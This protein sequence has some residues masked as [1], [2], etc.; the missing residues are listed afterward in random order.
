MVVR[1]LPPM[2]S[3]DYTSATKAVHEALLAAFAGHV[4]ARVE[5]LGVDPEEVGD[6]I[7]VGRRWLEVRYRELREL[8]PEQQRRSPLELFQAACAFPTERLESLGVAPVERDEVT[9]SALPGDLYDLAPASSQ[10]LGDD[11]WRAHVAW[12]VARASIVAGMVPRSE[13]EPEERAAVHVAVITG[14]LMDRTRIVDT[15]R[16]R[17]L[18]T[19]VWRN[20]GAVAKGLEET[21][22][23]VA[24]VDL[25]HG[26][27]DEIIRLLGDAGVRVIAY[28]PHVDDFALARAG[29]LGA[30]EVL[31][32]SRLFARLTDRLPRIV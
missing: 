23:V 6:A 13:A 15:A 24:F 17:G 21:K 19:A 25:E 2:T 27:S 12:G 31:T 1:N 3:P 7:E 9:V 22:P 5:A 14:N 16:D 18:S 4:R 30:T 26:A 8:P 28:G 29:S 11:V 10:D 20:P 32:R